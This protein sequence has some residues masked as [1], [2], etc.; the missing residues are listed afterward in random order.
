MTSLEKHHILVIDDDNRLRELLSR[1]LNQQEFLVTT[2]ASAEE[3]RL[4]L[5]GMQ[6][7]MLV[8]DVM[9]PGENGLD[10]VRDLK[11]SGMTTPCLMLTAM[12][13]PGQRL[14]GLE[15]GADD[16]MTKPFEPLE[17]ALRLQNILG[18]K[19]PAAADNNQ[20]SQSVRF[21]PHQFDLERQ[22]LMTGRQRRHLTSSEKALLSCFAENAGT[23]LS[24]EGLSV[25]LGGK[26]EGRSID[27]AVARLRRKL[28]PNPGRP[29]Y[30]LTARGLGWVLETDKSF[31][32]GSG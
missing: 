22:L 31:R 26:M 28:E 32:D 2:A 21:G 14:H 23:V 27:V 7:D 3:A 19:M 6:F 20:Q 1:F 13:E 9:M 17:L 16:Y 24:R 18:R 5:E 30:L 29:I 12:G 8:V 15:S 25:M 11:S 10:L 4:R